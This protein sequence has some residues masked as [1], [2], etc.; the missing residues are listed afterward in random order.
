[1]YFLRLEHGNKSYSRVSFYTFYTG[2][3]FKTDLLNASMDIEMDIAFQHAPGEDS[4][5]KHC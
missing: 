5:K 1:M 3:K 2:K 4:R